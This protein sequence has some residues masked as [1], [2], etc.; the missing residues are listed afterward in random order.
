ML[1]DTDEY[2]ILANK[3]LWDVMTPVDV[4]V[5]IKKEE[6]VLLAAKRVQDV[7]QSYG[8][9]ENLSIILIKFNNLGTD[10][11]F[12]MRE[13]RQTIRK[14]PTGG[15]VISG[16]CKCGCCCETNNSCCHSGANAQFM[17]QPSARSDRS[18]PSGQ[19][20]QASVNDTPKTPTP[21]RQPV[22]SSTIGISASKNLKGSDRK[23]LKNGIVRAV[24]ARIEEEKD[25]GESDSVMSEEQFK[26]WEY[27]LE[28]NTQLL[29]DKELDTISKAFTKRNQNNLARKHVRSLSTS[30]PAIS[31]PSNELN[32]NI[33][34]FTQFAAML[35]IPQNNA[36][37]V[38]QFNANQVN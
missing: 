12:L 32:P 34:N 33:T 17:R 19:S 6:N 15:S 37:A 5:E 35:N 27:M 29:F 18:S 14:K 23:N 11:D 10:I 4:A 13:L 28:Q 7:A 26:C 3:K 8:A 24:R 2:L 30:T 1:S 22:D 36:V 25:Q 16:F 9:E 38:N 21:I 31:I 20:D